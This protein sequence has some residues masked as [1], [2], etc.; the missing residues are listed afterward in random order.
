[1]SESAIEHA[2]LQRWLSV[3]DLVGAAGELEIEP[4]AGDV[5][6][7]RYYRVAVR[8][9]RLIVAFYPPELHS[10]ARR[11]ERTT[12]LLERAGV[13]VPAIRRVDADAGLMLIE[14]LGRETLF[15]WRAR[16]W[17]ALEPYLRAAH[18]AALRLR[19]IDPAA[20]GDPLL[21]PLDAA[22][23]ERELA[24]TWDVFLLPNR[25]VGD[26]PLSRRLLDHL[27]ALC[28]ALEAGGM[29]PCHRDLMARNLVPLAASGEVALL[30]HQDLRLGPVDYDTA[31]LFND[32]LYPAEERV[33]AMIGPAVHASAGY[34]RAVAQRT[35]KIVGTFA[36]FARR[37]H[38]RHLPLVAPSLRRGLDHLAALPESAALAADLERR[39]A[40]VLC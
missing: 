36:S 3:G 35:L 38:P 27:G 32:S 4:L 9:E 23:L 19:A 6:L 28:A 8:G 17:E 11:F 34:H 30:D 7:R 13:R 37:G 25:L 24:M 16:G 40:G 20:L 2:D 21:P 5:S 39:W 18:Q 31:S 26:D 1:M 14:D 22:V 29:V 12:A 10:V 15:D 33:A